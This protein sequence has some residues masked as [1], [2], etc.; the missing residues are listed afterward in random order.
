MDAIATRVLQETN[1]PSAS[2]GIVQNGKIAY[3]NAYGYA[4]LNPDVKAEPTMRYSIGSI[5]KQ[6]TAAAILLLQQQGKLSLDDTVSRWFPQLTDANQVTIRMLLSHTS[7]YQDYWP[8][9]YDMPPMLLPTTADAILTRW[10]EKPLDFPP[11]TQ[12]QYSN[13]NYVIAGKIVEKVSGQPLMQ[14][15]Q[16]YIFTPLQ[17]NSV[18]NTDIAKLGDTDAQGYYRHALGPQRVAPK[19]GA[20][21]MFAAGELAMPVHDL[22]LWNI[23]QMNRSLLSPTSYDEMFQDVKLKDGQ[24]SNYGLGVFLSDRSG[25]PVI[26]HSGEVSGFVSEDVVLPQDKVAVAVLTNEDASGAASQIANQIVGAM[27][28]LPEDTAM[29]DAAQ[30]KQIFVGLQD[31]K[32]DRTLFTDNCNAYFT[33]QALE[34]YSSSLKPLGAPLVFR[35]VSQELRGGMTFHAYEVIFP[36]QRL[37]VTTYVEPDGKLEQYL[38]IP[39]K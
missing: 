32:I 15:L 27:L 22:L 6:F 4:R 3:L 30:A 20:G 12:W 25:H 39:G 29:K 36:N 13:T 2:V 7:G 9:D 19:E 10:G 11:G 38:V 14:F 8:E 18:A 17:M 5:S 26:S 24:P 21:W 31:G 1:V 37:I 34:D 16:E 35:Q 33:Q 28:H 23:S